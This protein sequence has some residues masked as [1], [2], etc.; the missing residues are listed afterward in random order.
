METER[1]IRCRDCRY[2][3]HPTLIF[4]HILFAHRR[5][6]QPSEDSRYHNEITVEEKVKICEIVSD[7]VA[8]IRKAREDWIEIDRVVRQIKKEYY[9]SLIISN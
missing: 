6:A 1:W 4:R 3:L 2:F 7:F 5:L 8:G 9:F